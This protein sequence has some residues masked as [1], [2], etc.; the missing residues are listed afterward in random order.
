MRQKLR[1]GSAVHPV[2]RGPLR[3]AGAA[4]GHAGTTGAG[5]CGIDLWIAPDALA[6]FIR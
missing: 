5:G 1:S 2:Y 4:S 3:K 6:N